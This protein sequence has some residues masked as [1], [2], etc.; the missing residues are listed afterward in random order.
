MIHPLLKF[1]GIQLANDVINQLTKSLSAIQFFF[2]Q[3]EPKLSNKKELTRLFTQLQKN[4]SVS[5][6]DNQTV[7][8]LLLPYLV[9]AT[10]G[11]NSNNIYSVNAAWILLYNA[12]NLLDKIE[13]HE[14]SGILEN[15]L[16]DS[17][18][19]N[20]T[21][22]LLFSAA[23]FLDEEQLGL[24]HNH[25]VYFQKSLHTTGLKMCSGQHMDLTIQEPSL[26]QVWQIAEEKSGAFFELACHWGAYFACA[27]NDQYDKNII[28]NFMLFGNELGLLIQLAN[29]IEGLWGNEKK[30]S[31]IQS[32]K[33]TF[34]IAYAIEVLEPSQRMCLLD[35]LHIR[36]MN[37]NAEQKARSLIINYGA[38]VYLYL[39]IEKHKQIA[40]NI[41]ASIQNSGAPNFAMLALEQT[42]NS[43]QFVGKTND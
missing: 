6:I 1:F 34:P 23:S 39:E 16:C 17:T 7:N 13:D 35:I 27:I 26:A 24:S 25:C 32:G 22:S 2:D 5:E 36:K 12:F 11:A 42:I 3:K 28:N 38:L 41:L 33:W 18:L 31:D 14:T 9:F 40:R 10:S 37:K 15:D 4:V 21:T 29:D 30:D 8:L 20:L 43:F 19:L